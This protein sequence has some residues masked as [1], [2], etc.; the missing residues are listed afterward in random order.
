MIAA[1]Y[2]TADGVWLVHVHHD[3]QAELWR[4]PPGQRW[5]QVV[6]RNV[7]LYKVTDRLAAEGVA[8][9]DLIKD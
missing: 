2:R 8:P 4:K 5:P 3:Q 6:L 7:P 9:E 1:S